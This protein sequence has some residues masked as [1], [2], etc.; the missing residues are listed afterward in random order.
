MHT[1][2][3]VYICRMLWEIKINIKRVLKCHQDN[4][5]K[6]I[7]KM[8]IE[9]KLYKNIVVFLT[10]KIMD[11]KHTIQVIKILQ[12]IIKQIKEKGKVVIKSRKI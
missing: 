2:K 4:I 10:F 8:K 3:D 11:N 5:R 1:W 9:S 7:I 6:M 12:L